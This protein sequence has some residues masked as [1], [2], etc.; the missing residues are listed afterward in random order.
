MGNAI[1]E[2]SRVLVKN[3]DMH[4]CFRCGAPAGA[5]RGEWH[6]RRSRSVRDEHRHAA[7]NGVWL[8]GT[9]HRWVHAHPFEARGK[10]LIVSRYSATPCLVPV[11]SHFGWLVLACDGK[12]KYH[13]PD[14]ET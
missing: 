10:G 4:R 14:N 1:P 11:L 13:L 7:C 6:H 8:C 5:G 2:T 12:F 3:R 9:C